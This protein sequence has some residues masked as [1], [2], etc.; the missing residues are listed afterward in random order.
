[1]VVVGWERCDDDYGV[2]GGDEDSVYGRWRLSM[3][4]M[5]VGMQERNADNDIAGGMMIVVVGSM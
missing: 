2:V 1:M 3:V 5:H 4:I